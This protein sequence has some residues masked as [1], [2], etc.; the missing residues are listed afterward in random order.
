M[1]FEGSAGAGVET[2]F[3]DGG[4][5]EGNGEMVSKAMLNVGLWILN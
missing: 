1:S 5:V 3:H 4:G 2:S